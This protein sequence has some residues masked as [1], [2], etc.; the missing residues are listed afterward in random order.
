MS[1]D[2]ELICESD[3]IEDHRV[4]LIEQSESIF[5]PSKAQDNPGIRM[6]AEHQHHFS[7]ERNT[8]GSN[9]KCLRDFRSPFIE[10]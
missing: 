5:L 8:A 2:K 7:P 9:V 1:P 3:L 10:Q 6:S 4:L